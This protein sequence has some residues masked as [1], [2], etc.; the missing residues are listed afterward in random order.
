MAERSST[1]VED[2]SRAPAS[3]GGKS[4]DP[5]GTRSEVETRSDAE[6]GPAG[7]PAAGSDGERRGVE[8]SAGSAQKKPGAGKRP[9]AARTWIRRA[10][11]VPILI[12]LA[13]GIAILIKTFLVQAFYIPSGSMIPTLEVGDRVLVEKIGYRIGSPERGQVV[14]FERSLL[15]DGIEHD[16]GLVDTARTN[17]RELLGL[18]TGHQ[19]D[20]IKRIVAAGGDR[21]RYANSPRRLVVNGE[22]VREDY[23]RG[24]RDGGSPALT[25]QDCARLDM[26][27]SGNSCRVPAGMVFVMGDNRSNSEDSRALGPIGED[28]VV[29]RAFTVIW[30]F[31]HF[32][33]L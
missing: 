12:L 8:D 32:K 17:L 13:F 2:E 3:N 16:R 10:T 25:G 19:E 27:R 22:V 26:Q 4:T 5:A 9:S 31:G 1:T 24:G 6:D 11:E 30:P 21:I 29:G 14:V 33:G 7:R 28:K 23:L 20:Y 15:D 18:P